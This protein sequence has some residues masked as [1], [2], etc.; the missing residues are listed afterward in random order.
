MSTPPPV[1][2]TPGPPYDFA[3][4]EMPEVPAA[5]V[6]RET[7]RPVDLL[8]L[9]G[10]L[11]AA[12]VIVFAIG[13]IGMAVWMHAG[14]VATTAMS[15]SQMYAIA[16][17]LQV[18]WYLIAGAIA[19]PVFRRLWQ[20]SFAAGIHWNGQAALGV[21]TYLLIAAGIVLSFAVQLVSAKIKMPSTA[22]VYELFRNPALAWTATIFGVFIAPAME[23]LG[24]RGFLL[25][26]LNRWLGTIGGVI[27]T[28]VVFALLHAEQIGKA[29]GA[30]AVLFGVS[31]V[32]CVVRL[33]W[34]SVAAS[35]L[36]HMSYNAVLFS[37][38]I[39]ATG[40]YRH[41]DKLPH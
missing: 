23:E 21:R 40:G 28:S 34:R 9:L 24:F 26:A 36:V 6:S 14:H 29:W 38:M 15:K 11:L 4:P 1:P 18:L 35:T 20:Q 32:L 19:V 22:P 5:P 8:V 25:P 16:I 31:V 2:F 33:R 37:G 10:V 27:L 7:P 30:V 13:A 3:S 39:F 41:F 17:P 12:F